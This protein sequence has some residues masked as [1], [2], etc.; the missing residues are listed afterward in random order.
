[1]SST[2]F[3]T[4]SVFQQKFK[5][6]YSS[7]EL[8]EAALKDAEEAQINAAISYLATVL[9]YTNQEHLTLDDFYWELN[10][11]VEVRFFLKE[12]DTNE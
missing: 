5:G 1:M 3:Y 2:A 8:K 10:P 12:K 9:S 4:C 7:P 6:D 11:G